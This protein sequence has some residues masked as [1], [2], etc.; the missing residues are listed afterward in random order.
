MPTAHWGFALSFVICCVLI[1]CS[2]CCLIHCSSCC[3]MHCSFCCLVHCSF[4]SLMQYFLP[5]A[6]QKIQFPVFWAL[7]PGPR[8]RLAIECQPLIRDVRSHSLSVG[9]LIHCFCLLSHSLFLVSHPLLITLFNPTKT[10]SLCSGP[11]AQGQGP[12]G[13]SGH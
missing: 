2:F 9:V 8:A 12:L 7:S 10:I 13:P 11:W 1:H 5:C 3:L 4:C 6:T